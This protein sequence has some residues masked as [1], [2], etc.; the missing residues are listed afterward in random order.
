M[1][2]FETSVGGSGLIRNDGVRDGRQRTT[3][4]FTGDVFAVDLEHKS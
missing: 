2:K 4:V 3:V 1:G